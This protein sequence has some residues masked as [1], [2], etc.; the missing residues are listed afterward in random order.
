MNADGQRFHLLLGVGD[1]GGGRIDARNTLASV[2]ARPIGERPAIAPGWDEERHELTLAPIRDR[3]ASTPGEA[4]LS[5]DDRRAAASDAFGNV[6][7]IGSD[8]TQLYVQSRGDGSITRFWPD[9]RAKRPIHT[10][11]AAC[12][13]VLP[14]RPVYRALAATR[15]GWLIAAGDRTIDSFDLLA[16]GPPLHFDWPD[17]GTVITDLAARCESGLWLLDR[18]AR[19]LFVLDATLGAGG[20]L[21]APVRELFQPVVGEPRTRA[22]AVAA[23]GH[24]L[25][26]LDPAIDPVAIAALPGGAVAVLSR[27]PALLGLWL[28]EGVASSAPL[29]LDFTPHDMVAADVLLRGN[30][31]ALRVLVSDQTGNQLR[32]F[33]VEGEGAGIRLAETT[34]SF[35]LRRYG[36]L[37]LLSIEG[38]AVYDSGPDPRWARVVEKPRQQFR[39]SARFQTQVFDSETPSVVWDRLR[40]DG[41]VPPGATVGVEARA[42]DDRADLGEWRVQPAPILSRS[43]SELAAHPAAGI[44][45][46]DARAQHGTFE[47]LFQRIQGRFLEIRLTL[48]SDG[49]ASPRLRALRA[50][51]PRI[52]WSERY[53]PAVYRVEPEPADFLERFLANMQGTT[54]VIEARMIA[55]ERLFDTRTAPV[56]TLG[57]LAEWFDVAL[58]PSWSEPRRRLFIAHA[59]RF[60]GWRGTMRGLESALALAFGEPLKGTLFDDTT[61]TCSGAIRIVESYRT[62]VLGRI[63]AGDSSGVID[64]PTHDAGITERDNWVAFQ[65][66]RGVLEPLTTLPRLS[67][68][69]AY[70]EAWAEFLELVSHDRAAWQRFL[71]GRYRRIRA[72]NIA[73]GADWKAFDEIALCD[74][75]PAT[76]AARA[77]WD[78]FE[79]RLLP[80]DRTAHRFS[81]LLPVSAT[82]ATDGATLGARAS[83]ARRI[84]ALEKPAHTIFDVR[85]YFAMNRIG[86]A[87]LG[88]DT[89]IGAGSRA[90]EL[91]PPAILGRAYI[92]ESFM[93]ADGLPLTPDRARLSC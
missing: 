88:Y 46:T 51:W 36:G 70:A 66:V 41:C 79:H 27:A 32:A 49:D 25:T 59:V 6:Y 68:P 91:L 54:S 14:A 82:D 24:D 39:P 55:A 90:P 80:I 5:L 74:T 78:A 30:E 69:A 87:R 56:E 40:I 61:C 19:R 22:A 35:P 8:A 31:R 81:A 13:D 33:R 28:G 86:E 20:E 85:F 26:T 50:S 21:D 83:L 38:N 75:A 4:V 45:P 43:G 23:A 60:F 37:A 58:D 16:G 67:V 1:W 76:A 93:G 47:L 42:S 63:G 57:W 77:D 15:D 72:L 89:A 11:F 2:W 64:P 10:T 17:D 44:V 71:A 92:G 53:L 65:H 3:A 9:P 12:G 18:A 7:W 48:W 73:H 29:P 84:I 52:S 62:R 34:E